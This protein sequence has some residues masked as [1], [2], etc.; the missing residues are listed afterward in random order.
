M[1]IKRL[2]KNKM[3]G[4]YSAFFEHKNKYYYKEKTNE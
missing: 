1:E 3:G 4:G 2:F